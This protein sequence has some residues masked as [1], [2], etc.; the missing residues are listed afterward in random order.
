MFPILPRSA[1]VLLFLGLL[2]CPCTLSPFP[3]HRV[4]FQ[5][6]FF[7]LCGPLI[8]QMFSSVALYAVSVRTDVLVSTQEINFRESELLVNILFEE[9]CYS[10]VR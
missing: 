8:V 6:I 7:P 3:V 4:E 2:L 5:S 10:A 1:A 9:K